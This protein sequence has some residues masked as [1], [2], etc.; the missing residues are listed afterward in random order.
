MTAFIRLNQ[1][2]F[3]AE[4]FR[5]GSRKKKTDAMKCGD[6]RHYLKIFTKIESSARTALLFS[7]IT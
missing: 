2:F 1:G 4:D 5:I 6:T 3:F 7:K